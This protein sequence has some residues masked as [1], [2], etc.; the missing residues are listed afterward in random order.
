MI[1]YSAIAE[2][3]SLVMVSKAGRNH[4]NWIDSD[5]AFL[6]GLDVKE[7]KAL[8]STL[9]DKD[10][11][12]SKNLLFL[13]PISLVSNQEFYEKTDGKKI[14]QARQI[15]DS[16]TFDQWLK[17]KN[18]FVNTKIADEKVIYNPNPFVMIK[19][20]VE[21]FA[22][23]I[24]NLVTGAISP[25]HMSGPIGMVKLVSD[26]SQSSI[27]TGVYWLGMISLNLAFMNML[28]IPM[29]DG[30]RICIFIYEMVSRKRLKEKTMQRLILP[31]FALMI[32]LFIYITFYDIVKLFS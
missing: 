2:R 21:E 30:G 25:K 4:S 14:E 23:S 24:K 1:F 13:S 31:F 27:T 32:V 18:L 11:S 20:L 6:S 9:G 26:S 17:K 10:L 15:L 7:I 28:P 16:E 22:F 8:E 29:L 5:Q 3:K 19:E 12:Q